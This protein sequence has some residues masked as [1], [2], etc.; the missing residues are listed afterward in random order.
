MRQIAADLAEAGIGVWLDERELLPGSRLVSGLAEGLGGADYVL[1]FVSSSFLNSRWADVEADAALRKSIESR[2]AS[3]IPLL[4]EDVWPRVSLLLQS[5]IYQDFREAENVLAYRAALGRVVAA[6]KRSQPVLAHTRRKIGILVSG[7]REEEGGER[8]RS[9]A[10]ELGRKLVVLDGP[11][12]TGVAVGVDAA[13]AKGVKQGSRELGVDPRDRLT[14]YAN[15][16]KEPHQKIGKILTSKFRSRHEGIPELVTL[17]DIAFLIGGGKN[18]IFLGV[19]M[20]L[21]NKLVFP[22]ATTGGAAEDCYDLVLSRYDRVFKGTLPRSRF[23]DLGDQGLSAS[24]LVQRCV[25]LV[26]WLKGDDGAT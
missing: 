26:R 12:F 6:I 10:T 19:L 3:V 1:L 24:E 2:K 20:L 7:G 4:L 13:F 17:A 22:L 21:E 15:K 5:L 8:G 9:I 11:L 18:T 14:C 23:E 25:N 16:G